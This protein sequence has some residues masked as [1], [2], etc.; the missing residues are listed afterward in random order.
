[1]MPRRLHP[2]QTTST[3]SGE[4][5]SYVAARRETVGPR[6]ALAIRSKIRKRP[7]RLEM[8]PSRIGIRKRP[9]LTSRR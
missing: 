8:G 4:L 5:R 2:R 1:M 3:G 9:F 6:N 7:S